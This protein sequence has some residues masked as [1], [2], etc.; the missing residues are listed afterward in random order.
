MRPLS[1]ELKKE[2]MSL[3]AFY[4]RKG[5]QGQ[6]PVPT[7]LSRFPEQKSTQNTFIKSAYETLLIKTI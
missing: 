3:R 2:G 6:L 7:N 1:R 5:L 4:N